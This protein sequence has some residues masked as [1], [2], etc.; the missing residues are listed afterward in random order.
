MTVTASVR[1]EVLPAAPKDLFIDGVWTKAAEGRTFRVLDPGTGEV[2][3]TVADASPADGRRALEAA[4]AAQSAFAALTPRE[5]QQILHRALA[6]VA[7][8]REDLATILTLESG[9]PLHESR[10]ELTSVAEWI[11]HFAE[12]A[13]RVHGSFQENP[14]VNGRM[15]VTKQ[16]IGPSILITPWNFPLSQAVRKLA[17]AIAAGCTS[18][19]KPAKET[20]LAVLAFVKLLADAGVP[21]GA[22]N[23][24]TTSESNAVMEP[25]IRSGLARKLSFTGSTPV[26]VRL[27]EQAAEQ[28]LSCSM[29]LGGNAP[30]IVFEDA[31]LD[32]AVDSLMVNKMWNCGQTCTSANR[33]FVHATLMD[34][35]ERRV[36]ERLAPMVQGH[37]MDDGVT[38]G[39]L[40]NERQ[41]RHVQAMVDDAVGHGARLVMGGHRLDRPG[42]FYPP[43]VLRDVPASAELMRE[44]V[45]GPVVALIPFE[46]ETDVVQRANDT[47]Y[48]L[49]SYVFTESLRRAVR[50]AE[51]LESGNVGL[52]RGT[53]AYAAAPFGGTKR[54]GLGREG[55]TEG[56]EE[57]LETK[58]VALQL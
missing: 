47:D 49:V 56:I 11:Q 25:L 35:F 57:F 48:G 30:F 15:I 24:V 10:A 6:L 31:D 32:V 26:G 58:F 28:V 17:P 55:A 22:V 39:P 50:V 20:P 18:V 46:E 27:L 7:E 33:V 29:E 40:V 4:V 19:V 1:P 37:G 8:R 43:T 14:G 38:L 53:V 13:V 52:N 3:C 5:R 42:T 54:S 21:P 44:E 36:T 23:A 2:L 34:E 41:V 12:E 9:K 16:P 45:F 51:A